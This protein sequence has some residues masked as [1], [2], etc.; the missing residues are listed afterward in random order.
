MAY[1]MNPDGG[2]SAVELS[3][4]KETWHSN[5]A[6]TPLTLSGDFLVS[7]A[8]AKDSA[9]ELRIVTLDTREQGRQVAESAV[10][11][12]PGVS[13]SISRSPNKLF[14]AN[15]R[16]IDGDAA[17]TWQYVE[18]PV[19][20]AA[21]RHAE[22]LPGES[23]PAVPPRTPELRRAGQFRVDFSTGVVKSQELD[24]PT[25]PSSER[26]P[27]I[28]AQDH[29]PDVPEPQFL[30]ADGKHVLSSQLAGDDSIWEKYRWTI[31][32]RSDRQRVGQL[33]SHVAFAPFFVL[34]SKVIYETGPYAR[35]TSTGVIEEPR[36]IRAVDLNT[37]DRLWTQ[38]VRDLAA[39]ASPPP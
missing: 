19:R 8:E 38:A 32:Q 18:R 9:G 12:P 6:A 26:A 34:D 4:G 25:A 36:Q 10:Q 2:I 37:G 31:Y 11:L 7:Q 28:S 3:S 29:L 5:Q 20:G 23:K 1:V 16:I 22:V 13:A 30:S 39:R 17:V 24:T 15:A 21:P 14:T 33:K 27:E 35:R